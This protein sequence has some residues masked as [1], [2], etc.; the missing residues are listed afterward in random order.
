MGD[1]KHLDPVQ[2]NLIET[3]EQALECARSGEITGFILISEHIGGVYTA[4]WPGAFSTDMDDLSALIGH[5]SIAQT[6]FAMHS[7]SDDTEEYEYE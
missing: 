5:L 7:L 2:N 6:Y 3:L 4:D 1:V